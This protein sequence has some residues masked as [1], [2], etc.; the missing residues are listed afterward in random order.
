MRTIVQRI[1]KGNR[2]LWFAE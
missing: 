1:R 2:H